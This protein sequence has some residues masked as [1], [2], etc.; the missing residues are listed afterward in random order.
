MPLLRRLASYY[1]NKTMPKIHP[2]AIVDPSAQIADDVEI[3][4]GCVIES[5]VTIGPGCVLGEYVIVRKYTTFGSNNRADAF[6][7]FGGVP[8]DFKFDPNC[9]SYLNIGDDNV[10]R[11]KVTLSR[12]TGEGSSTEVGN[13]TFWMASAHGGHNAFIGDD[14]VLVNCSVVG[15]HARL[16]HKATLLAGAGI[17]QFTWVGEM[18]LIQG[19]GIATMHTP[20]YVIAS[21]INHVV[22]L[23]SVG[24]RQSDVIS[25]E[26]HRQITEAFGITYGG[27]LTATKVLQKMDAC[28][29]WD[30]AANKFRQFVHRA[31]EAQPPYKRGLSPLR[32]RPRAQRL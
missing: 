24:L 20:P 21:G 14:A 23:N 3:G 26:D 5:D 25:E 2:T 8:Q 32:A 13:R 7:V 28:T 9:V 29:D 10:F 18:S 16:E 12:G 19:K 15:G 4:P 1:R 22:G 11:E 30:E 31:I 17:H 27:G 6:G